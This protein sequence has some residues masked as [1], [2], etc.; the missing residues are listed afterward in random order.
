MTMEG[1]MDGARHDGR[2]EATMDGARRRWTARGTIDG[3]R[4]WPSADEGSVFRRSH[5]AQCV[6]RDPW[7]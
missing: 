1:A 6:W 4:R 5:R 7:E 2:R 3:A